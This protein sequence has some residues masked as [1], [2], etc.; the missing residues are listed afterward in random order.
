MS[1]ITHTADITNFTPDGGFFMDL[2]IVTSDGWGV[3]EVSG[4]YIG[5][6]GTFG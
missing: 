3:R 2:I 5:W 6:G 4:L 1:F